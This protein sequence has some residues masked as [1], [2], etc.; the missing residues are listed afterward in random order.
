MGRI[1]RSPDLTKQ[2]LYAVT[3]VFAFNALSA[4]LFMVSVRRPVYDDPFNMFDVRAYAAHG[5]S[6]AAIRA[7]RNAPG[8]TSFIWMASAARFIGHDELLD[9]RIAIFFSWFLLTLAI[10]VGARYSEWPQLWF[11][12]LLSALVFP[13]SAIASATALTEGPALLFALAGV[14][15]WLESVSRQ[16]RISTASLTAGVIGGLSIGLA[17]TCRKYFLALLPAA[18]VLALILLKDRPSEGTYKWFGSIIASLTVTM[19]PVL[20]LVLIWR[21]FTSPR[22]ATGSSYSNYHA[23]V[24]LAWFRPVVVTLFAAIYLVPYSFPALWQVSLKRRWTA[25]LS[26]FLVAFVA[27]Y[28][29]DTFLELGL[30]HTLVQAASRIPAGGEVLFWLITSVATYNAIADCLLLWGERSR[31]RTCV[32]VAFAILVVFFFIAEQ[33]GV[34]GNIP[35]YDRYVLQLAPFLG[36][37]GFWLFPRFTWSRILAIAGLATVSHATLWQH[38]IIGRVAH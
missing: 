2:Y 18:G 10:V 1:W 37:I 13:H 29:K 17:I 23:S 19:I 27:T 36:L 12:A 6:F 26:A 16:T 20:L 34:G 8:P 35:F 11:G 32:P 31:L 24:E 22:M 14:L 7:Q 33:F 38:A 25:L 28:F 3:L 9:A 5:I 30:L 15:A 4:I 21:G